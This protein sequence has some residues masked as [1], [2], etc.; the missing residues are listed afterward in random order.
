MLLNEEQALFRETA[1][2]FARELLLS[3]AADWDRDGTFPCD[4]VRGMGKLGFLGM[5]VPAD[6][7]GVGADHVAYAAM[8]EEIAAGCCGLLT[9]LSSHN[10]IGCLPIIQYGTEVQQS[11]YLPALPSGEK[12]SCFCLTEPHA[13]SDA[14]TLRTTATRENGHYVL[15]RTKQFVTTGQNADIA[16]VFA[17][18]GPDPGKRGIS[19][20]IVP[21]DQPGYI[22]TRVE[23]SLANTPR[24]PVKS[25]WMMSRYRR[26][27][28]LAKKAKAIASRWPIWKAAASA[29]PRRWSAWPAQPMR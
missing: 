24:T 27:T 14:S 1:A 21:T 16:L 20:F 10:S 28:G 13:G 26:K 17:Q 8:L 18:T 19:A 25:C 9:V 12:S 29:S 15:N 5:L 6:K 2:R 11:R 22:V 4:T 7:G 3:F 23:G